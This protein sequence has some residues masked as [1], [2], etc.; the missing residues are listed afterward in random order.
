MTAGDFNGDGAIDLA[1]VNKESDAFSVLLG[2]NND[3]TFRW[4]QS[5]DVGREPV[6]LTTGDFDN[7]GTPD[8]ASANRESADVSVR[9]NQRENGGMGG[10]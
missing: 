9:L 8:V 2:N 7:D 3:G 6:S 10:D 5:F 1:T 4:Y